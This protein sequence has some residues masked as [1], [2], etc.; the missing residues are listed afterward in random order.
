MYAAGRAHPLREPSRAILA[1]AQSDERFFTNAEVFQELLHRYRS[2]GLWGAR[3]QHYTDFMTLMQGRIESIVA[4]DM[5]VAARLAQAYP[6][7]ASRDL[8]HLAVALR[9]GAQYIVTADAGFDDV[10]EIERLNPAAVDDW[11][12]RVLAV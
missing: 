5:E 6:E 8:V 7:L 2:I 12:S 10:A 9:M 11:R 1:L 3:V 4:D